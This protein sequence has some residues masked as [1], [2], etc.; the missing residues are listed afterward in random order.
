MRVL[1][2]G[3]DW[4]EVQAVWSSSRLHLTGQATAIRKLRA[5]CGALQLSQ[6][7]QWGCQ[8][9]ID[10]CAA[11]WVGWGE[12]M[13]CVGQ[14]LFA[15]DWAATAVGKPRAL[16][17]SLQLSQGLRHGLSRRK[18]VCCFY[19]AICAACVLLA[20]CGTLQLSQGTHGCGKLQC[21]GAPPALHT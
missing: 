13:S 14:Q 12:G 15:P 17:V 20:L 18:G 21:S 1:R 7:K 11:S 4:L 19:S 8:G 3:W 16:C 6:G 5:V 2:G 9:V 10:A